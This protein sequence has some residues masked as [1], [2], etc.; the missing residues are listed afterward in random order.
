MPETFRN[1][2]PD[3]IRALL[4]EVRSIAVVGF[5][6]EPSRPSHRVAAAL[7]QVGY[8]IIPVRPGIVSG[9]GETAWRDLADIPDVARTVDLVDVFRAPD[10]VMPVVDAC[11]ALGLKRLWLQDGVVNEEAA[12]RASAAGIEVVMNDCT[13]RAWSTLGVG[14]QGDVAGRTK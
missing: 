8:R 11:I 4:R 7:Q 13:W 14:L 12:A 6:P 2:S 9:L 3:R 5:S 1:P 10:Q